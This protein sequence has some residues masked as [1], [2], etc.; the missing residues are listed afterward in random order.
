MDFFLVLTKYG[1]TNLNQIGVRKSHP[2]LK[3]SCQIATSYYFYWEKIKFLMESLTEMK[4]SGNE[5]F[6]KIVQ[7]LSGNQ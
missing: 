6:R 2:G 4:M 5:V 7:P 3:C 1:K